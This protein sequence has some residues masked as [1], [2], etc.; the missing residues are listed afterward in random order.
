MPEIYIY[1]SKAKVEQL[2]DQKPSFLSNVTA[3]L[4]FKFPFISG[5]L[6]G[7]TESRILKELKRLLPLLHREY[8]MPNFSNIDTTT[9]PVFFTFHGPAVRTIEE[10]Q[11][12]LAMEDDQVALL[13]AGSA[14]N[15]L[16]NAT[17]KSDR[18][19]P[20][21]DP[22]GSFC[23]A[24]KN[25]DA[26]T[27]QGLSSDLSYVWQELMADSI[28][29]KATLPYVEGIAIFAAR[30]QAAKGQMRRVNRASI[31]S[32]VIGTPL[33]VKQVSACKQ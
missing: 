3:K 8:H 6:S 24:A 16:G 21:A 10:G 13:L 9:S 28:M 27:H 25:S 32:L 33:F 4:D 31:R 18:I 7:K 30:L 26:I 11:F 5:G 22:V 15:A 1:I 29:S 17:A 2:I 19:S 14:S 12:W 23:R 20:S